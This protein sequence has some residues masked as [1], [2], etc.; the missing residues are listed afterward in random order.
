M[1]F[2]EFI[3]DNTDGR[4]RAKYKQEKTDTTAEAS[5]RKK[6]TFRWAGTVFLFVPPEKHHNLLSKVHQSMQ[7]DRT[8]LV[9]KNGPHLTN[10]ITTLLRNLGWKLDKKKKWSLFW[11]H[12]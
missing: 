2:T 12:F 11:L 6:L 3:S 5:E 10:T 7:K 1:L 9:N 4:A 8:E